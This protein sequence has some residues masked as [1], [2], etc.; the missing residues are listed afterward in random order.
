MPASTFLL[1]HLALLSVP[2]ETEASANRDPDVCARAARNGAAAAPAASVVAAL[3]GFAAAWIAAGSTGVLAHSLRHVLT[4]LV[5]GVAIVAEWPGLGRP[6]RRLL[7][8]SAGAIMAM[9]MTASPL[10][11]VNVLAVAV[12]LCALSAGGS[13][14]GK[15]IMLSASAAVA[16]LGVYRLA[17]TSVPLLWMFADAVGGIMGRI[18]GLITGE[19]LWIGATFAGVDFLVL[20]GGL[21]AVWLANTRPPRRTRAIYGA[22]GILAGHLTYLIVLSFSA[23]LL[24]ALPDAAP[25]SGWTWA[26]ATRKGVP[27]NL[28]ALAAAI[29]LSVAALMLRWSAWPGP[30]EK[31]PRKSLGS[32]AWG[33]RA[34]PLVV[35]GAAL[36]L[37]A[38]TTLSLG[39]A[40]LTGKKIVAYEKGFLNWLR[41][42]HGSYGR[43][44][45][46]MYGM[47]PTWVESLGGRCLISPDLSEEDLSDA[48]VLILLFPD[49]PWAEGQLERIW[50]FVRRGGSLL[51]MGEHTTREQSGDSYFN[52]VLEPTG[53]RVCFDSA[54]FEVGGW[55][56]CYEALAHPAAAGIG[57][58]SNQ[59]GVVIG[60]SVEARLPA[61]ALLVGRWGWADPGDEGN[62][63]SM[64]GNHRYDPGERLGDIILAAEQPYGKGKVVAFGDTSS[65]TNGIKIGSHVYMN[66][67]LGY[68]AGGVCTPQAMWRQLLGLMGAA[69]LVVLLAWRAD[70][71]SVALVATAAAFSLALCTVVSHRAGE[72]LPDG[73]GQSPNNLAYIDAS[74]IE[75]YSPESWRTEGT[76]GLS[77]TLMREGYQVLM[78]PEVTSERLQGAGLLVSIAPSLEFSKAERRAVREFVER[79]GVFIITVGYDDWEPSRSLLSEFGFFVGLPA[80][81]IAKRPREPEPMGHFKSRYLMTQDYTAHVRFHAAWP[82][83]CI[84]PDARVIAYGKGDVPVIMMRQVGTGKVLLVGDTCF[85]MNKNLENRDGAA[86]EGKREN[87]DFWRWL[88]T[89]LT[90]RPAWQ[91]RKPQRQTPGPR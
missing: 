89:Q 61:R 6:R 27:W 30:S 47:L 74:H 77:L 25:D 32:R 22:L 84:D 41:P 55:L 49:E 23:K 21:Y 69:V 17:C 1:R 67:L 54:T 37:P 36:L 39:K 31:A 33:R 45:I 50:G 60:A 51:V 70:G 18:A 56:H 8:L 72:V 87:A 10:H 26:G 83:G 7:A 43:L 76:M 66:R 68:L 88:A 40:D 4:W 78:L 44:S 65:I 15:R 9:V 24:Q 59:F 29:H 62:P 81:G 58:E 46:G 80:V 34:L 2:M 91:P 90:D 16:V 85:A 12:M 73:Q 42:E 71:L 53:I 57:D 82:V 64:M 48:D 79:G 28:P 75:A 14:P 5:L 63:P 11:A 38:I 13:R 86:F 52:E 35:V 3:A 19:P 20:M